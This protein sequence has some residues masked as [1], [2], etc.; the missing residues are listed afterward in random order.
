M[1]D[2]DDGNVEYRNRNRIIFLCIGLVKKF[3][4]QDLQPHVRDI[5]SELNCILCSIT[6]YDEQSLLAKKVEVI[7]AHFRSARLP[8]S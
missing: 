1:D 4:E 2:G 8:R 5:L 7:V 3:Q 6:V